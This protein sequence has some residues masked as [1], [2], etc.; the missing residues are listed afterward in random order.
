MESL[1][2]TNNLTRS[3]GKI[4]KVNIDFNLDDL[5]QIQRVTV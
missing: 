2:G 4:I 5:P 3:N 1:F